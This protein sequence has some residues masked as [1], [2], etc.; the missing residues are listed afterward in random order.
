MPQPPRQRPIPADDARYGPVALALFIVYV[1]WGSTY[2]A[3]RF[4]VQ[5]LPPL[6]MAGS[7][8]LLAGAIL[9]LILRL[10]GAPPPD[11]S[12]WLGAALVGVL[13]LVV[14]NGVVA[15]AI[16]WVPS[17][18]AAIELATVPLWAA[19]FAGLWGTWPARV[20]WLGIGLGLIG[21]VLLNWE[22]D[23]RAYPAGALALLLAAVSW[24][25]GSIWSRYL[26]LPAGLMA[27]AAEMLAG[28]ALLIGLSAVF[29]ERLPASL[30]PS[31]LGALL[32]LVVFGSLVG[33]SAYNYLLRQVRPALATSNAYVNPVVAVGLGAGLGGEQVTG[34][35]VLALLVILAG[36]GLIALGRQRS[37]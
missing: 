20:E 7:R 16:Q 29:G 23:L 27:A 8:F 9:Y 5:G 19:L 22:G 36:V 31:A 21:M 1:V 11:R 25:L 37:F 12:Q 2:L 18:L 10:R 35:A 13:L 32:Y 34:T 17:G 3:M 33:F 14:G 28:G 6:L 24:A 4:A 26:T 30:A 15:Y